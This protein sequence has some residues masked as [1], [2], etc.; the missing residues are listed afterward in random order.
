M[1]CK[2]HKV[3]YL[4][5]V[6]CLLPY[7]QL[8]IW[9]CISMGSILQ[10]IQNLH[11]CCICFSP[12][13]WDYFQMDLVKFS[14]FFILSDH[15]RLQTM[16]RFSMRTHLS[17]ALHHFTNTCLPHGEPCFI[18]SNFILDSSFLCCAWLCCHTH[19]S[20]SCSCFLFHSATAMQ[21]HHV[22][23]LCYACPR[24]YWQIWYKHVHTLCQ[25]IKTKELTG[26]P[27]LILLEFH[28]SQQTCSTHSLISGLSCLVDNLRH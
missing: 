12:T 11:G 21:L 15:F 19:T 23:N 5:L 6:V 8:D 17:H 25:Y 3:P 10:T 7:L 22:I 4:C 16:R 2:S 18:K 27:S 14:L 1:P 9:H 24:Q 13:H 28:P 20:P 26:N